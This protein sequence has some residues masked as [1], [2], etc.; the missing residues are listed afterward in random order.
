MRKKKS[1]KKPVL[2]VKQPLQQNPNDIKALKK[3]QEIADTKKKQA[4]VDLGV[5][6]LEQRR[7]IL[8][9]ARDK[10]LKKILTACTFYEGLLRDSSAL[11]D[12]VE[13]HK[14]EA[15]QV[16]DGD[17]RI[18]NEHVLMKRMRDISIYLLSNRDID[19][20]PGKLLG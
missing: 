9:R 18:R 5:Q 13:K 16:A 4:A 1:K 17:A 19:F 8:S 20:I 2:P 3:A 6:A 15:V 10:T 7:R 12:I 14:L 11:V